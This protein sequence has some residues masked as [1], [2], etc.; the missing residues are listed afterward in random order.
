MAIYKKAHAKKRELSFF[1][2]KNITDNSADLYIYGDIIDD[3]WA[4]YVGSGYVMPMQIQ[5]QLS[6]LDGKNLN[7]YINS[8]GGFV[9]AG[10]AI[11]N[12]LARHNGTTCAI[13]DGW[14]ASIASIIAFSCD[15][16]QMRANTFLM[17]HRPSCGIVGNV[18]DMQQCIDFLSVIEA[19][20]LTTYQAKAKEGVT[21]EDI[22]A[23]MKAETWYTAADAAEKYN[24]EIIPAA[25]EAAAYAGTDVFMNFKSVPEAVLTAKRKPSQED[26]AER[27]RVAKEK[28]TAAEKAIAQQQ[29][30]MNSLL[31][32]EVL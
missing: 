24:I 2:V 21:A 6:E 1:Q 8:D 23:D 3:T 30:I 27:E 31:E 19:G 18:D 32:S 14:A 4:D 15:Q 16:I 17:I 26:L 25:N 12:M 22:Q 10:L 28:A 5:Q 9:S 20:M 29:L 13:I 11:A 7:V